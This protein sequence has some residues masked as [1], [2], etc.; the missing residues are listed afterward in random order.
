VTSLVFDAL[1]VASILVVIVLGMAV[2]VSMMGIFNL[3]HG[4]FV[5]LGAVAYLVTHNHGVPGLPAILIA[6]VVVGAIGAAME[7]T[8]IRR[9]YARPIAAVL[10]TWGASLIIRELVRRGIG[11]NGR[12]TTAPIGGTTRIGSYQLETWRL[13]VIGI[14]VVVVLASFAIVARTTLGLKV[15][16]TLD[17]RDLARAMGIRTKWLYTLT[18]AF[19]AGLAA[20]SGALVA[21]LTAVYP[22]LGVTYLVQAFLAV[23]VGGPGTFI[24]PILGAALVGVSSVGLARVMTPVHAEVAVVLGAVVMMRIRPRG[25]VPAPA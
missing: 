19:G 5:L 20:L 7:I 16:A 8:V 3:A 12:G 21:P 17:E 13:C 6:I 10:A 22:G 25:L 9:L 14:A 2:I 15:R 24:G 4:E 18:F 23:M 11:T 1:S